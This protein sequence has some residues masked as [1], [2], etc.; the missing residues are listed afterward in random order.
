MTVL[1]YRQHHRCSKVAPFFF[2]TYFKIQNT[3]GQVL[4]FVKLSYEHHE[5]LT[6][7][8]LRI[9]QLYLFVGLSC[10]PWN[11]VENSIVHSK[12]CTIVGYSNKVG[13]CIGLIISDNR[14]GVTF[15]QVS[16]LITGTQ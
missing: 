1:C 8:A 7:L 11:G 3:C 15:D 2:C 4:Q 14:E 5:P 9:E 13:W 10:C 6:G 12:Y 16:N